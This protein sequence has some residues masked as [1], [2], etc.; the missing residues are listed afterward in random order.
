MKALRPT[1][2]DLAVF[3]VL[4]GLA[5]LVGVGFWGYS[6]DDAF[7]TYR[8]ARNFAEHGELVFNP[9]E[10]VLGTTAP[11]YALLL[12]ALTFL[13][14]I[15][16]PGWGT[17]ISLAS[18]GA[19]ALVLRLA[20]ADAPPGVRYGA[21]LLYGTAAFL[22]RW[23]V[24]MF[25][26]ESFPVLALGVGAAW[27]AL[28]DEEGRRREVAAG[29]LIALAMIFR[30]DAA[31]LA[32]IL[33]LAL[34]WRRRRFP[35]AFA[36]AGL[37]PVL[38]FLLYLHLT[39]GA[40]IPNT[41]AAK[42]SELP[43]AYS[44]TLEEWRWLGRSL[45]FV[46]RLSLLLAVLGAVLFGS[47]P[48]ARRRGAAGAV[49]LVL[50]LW[51][52]AHELA[53][54][55]LAVPFAPWYHVP[56]INGLLAAAAL[57][58]TAWSWDER[59]AGARWGS[60]GMLLLLFPLLVQ[61][62]HYA[63]RQWGQAPDPR[64][65]GY[66]EAARRVRDGGGR[67][68]AAVEIGFLGYESDARVL[69]LMGLVSPEA[70]TARRDG[71]LPALVARERPDYLVDVSLFQPVLGPILDEPAVQAS[72]QPVAE[73]PDGRGPGVRLRLLRKSLTP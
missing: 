47:L 69:D 65:S 25:G 19:V 7:I 70:L 71:T 57:G 60:F 48:L 17:L 61:S 46:G 31:L 49:A 40:V 73:L 30:L 29:L 66:M 44:Y 1:P 52:A 51:L 10:R 4:A 55:V 36:L 15:S 53:Y 58:G 5:V 24:E 39:F 13:T 23:N 38:L 62:A 56:M 22:F 27:L 6:Y 2:G 37:V 3:A 26:A 20:L 11:G 50:I 8:Y 72:Y 64:W 43:A 28:G 32:G 63:V 45:T 21:P 68:V 41:M 42:Q 9:G 16:V 35:L 34:W 18:I 54:R 14:G 12:G 67:S 33:G 59:R